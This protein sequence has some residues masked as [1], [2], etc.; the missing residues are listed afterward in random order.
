MEEVL[1][2]VADTH[3]HVPY[4]WQGVDCFMCEGDAQCEHQQHF[5]HPFHLVVKTAM[6]MSTGVS[7]WE[8]V[9]TAFINDSP[10]SNNLLLNETD[11]QNQSP[12]AV[13]TTTTKARRNRKKG[14]RVGDVDPQDPLMKSDNYNC[15]HPQDLSN[16]I[17]FYGVHPWYAH[18]QPVLWSQRLQHLLGMDKNACVGESGLDFKAVTEEGVVDR[19]RQLE[20]FATCLEVAGKFNRPVSAHCVKAYQAFASM[21]T[22]PPFKGP[23]PPAIS[24]H[25]Y[26]GSAEFASLLLTTS[27]RLNVDLFFGFSCA[28]NLRSIKRCRRSLQAIPIEHILLESDVTHLSVASVEMCAMLETIAQVK[29]IELPKLVT[30]LNSNARRFIASIA[31]DPLRPR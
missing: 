27:K 13:D 29:G 10:Q 5:K 6:L 9:E 16:V 18:K 22:N 8:D 30:Q 11:N 31:E 24:M 19:E 15:E 14:I 26:G 21:L 2:E 4:D 17:R 28:I 20:A 23:L 3:C 25:S 12:D 1:Y 7:D